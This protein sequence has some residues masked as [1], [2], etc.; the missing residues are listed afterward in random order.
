MIIRLAKWSQGQERGPL[1]YQQLLTCSKGQRRRTICSAGFLTKSWK[2]IMGSGLTTSSCYPRSTQAR[3]RIKERGLGKQESVDCP[4]GGMGKLYRASALS[5]IAS[6]ES[7]IRREI[8]DNGP[9]IANSWGEEWG[10]EGFFRIRRGSNECDIE[11]FILSFSL[12]RKV[13]P[14]RNSKLTHHSLHQ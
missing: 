8:Y 14:R 12:E 11:E 9:V 1:S 3:C 7:A 4:G 5:R 2:Y 6:N 13:R 10:E